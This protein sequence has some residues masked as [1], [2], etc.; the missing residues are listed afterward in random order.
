MDCVWGRGRVGGLWKMLKEKYCKEENFFFLNL[1]A[2]TDICKRCVQQALPTQC[3]MLF[4]EP[5]VNMTKDDQEN[6]WN[7]CVFKKL[8]R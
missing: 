4:S 8:Q 1:A 7:E 3:R 2:F 6:E 5:L